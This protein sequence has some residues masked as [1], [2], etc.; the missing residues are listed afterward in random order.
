M[1]TGKFPVAAVA[2]VDGVDA[3]H[4]APSGLDLHSLPQCSF[5]P[6]RMALSVVWL[7]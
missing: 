2:F 4:C 6:Q 1:L 3:A 7:L 5:H